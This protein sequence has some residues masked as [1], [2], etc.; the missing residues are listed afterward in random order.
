MQRTRDLLFRFP[1]MRGEDVRAVQLALITLNIEPPCGAADGIFGP[2][3]GE[4]V[5]AFQRGRGG[6]K[7]DGIVGENTWNALF[8]SAASSSS[9]LVRETSQAVAPSGTAAATARPANVLPEGT[10]GPMREQ[11]PGSPALARQVRDWLMGNFGAQIDA[12]VQG[13]PY[14]AR[15]ICAIA[16]KEAAI[17]WFGWTS[18]MSAPDVLAHCVFDASGDDPSSPRSAFPKNTAEFRARYGDAFTDMLIAQA[19]A[20]RQLRGMSPAQMVYKGYGIF[21]YDLQHVVDDEPFF[22]DRRWGNFDDCLSRAVLELDRKAVGATTIR[23]IARRY[24]GAG[25]RAE[26]YANHILE[27]RRW[28]ATTDGARPSPIVTDS[29]EAG[30]YVAP[31]PESYVGRSVG[32]GQCVAF[33]QEA[34]GAPH[35][36]RWKAGPFVK[37]ATLERGTAIATF[38]P[39]GTYGN[40]IDGRSHA[41][42]YLDQDDVGLRVLDQWRDN[43]VHPVS[44]RVIR[45]NGTLPVNDGDHF[46]VIL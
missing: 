39:N 44:E 11:P 15:L 36:S 22:R 25:A 28:L 35:T 33:V 1:L 7:V 16:V 41:A 21:Q 45:F 24:N 46:R 37:G 18:R 2:A 6:L 14:D 5:K 38:D 10:I 3:T 30:P 9:P 26:E 17:Y 27:I 31:D 20:M 40:H 19:N 4:T 8:A 23:D 42:I 13:K 32:S 29:D 43:P 34:S 12:A